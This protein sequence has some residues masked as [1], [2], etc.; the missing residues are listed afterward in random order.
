MAISLLHKTWYLN[1]NGSGYVFY[2]S[3]YFDV[4]KPVARLHEI[5]MTEFDDFHIKMPS[6]I[7]IVTFYTPKKEI[8]WTVFTLKLIHFNWTRLPNPT[9]TAF[10]SH[11]NQRR[12]NWY[13]SK[14]IKTWTHPLCIAIKY[15]LWWVIM[16][17]YCTKSQ[18]IVLILWICV[19][20]SN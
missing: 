9:K 3:S 12:S 19:W 20:Q 6:K 8:K 2:I 18:F 14:S 11:P 17:L 7:S 10:S 15:T 13:H 5:I 4:S 1:S 16:R